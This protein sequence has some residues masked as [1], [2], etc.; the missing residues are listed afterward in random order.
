MTR[1]AFGPGK[2]ADYT[3]K[4][5]LICKAPKKL[6]EKYFTPT[7]IR[8]GRF[9]TLFQTKEVFGQATRVW[10]SG[11]KAVLEAPMKIV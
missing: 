9:I 10:E 11:E 1:N 6:Y 5:F 7:K 4:M 3:W 8:N 2:K